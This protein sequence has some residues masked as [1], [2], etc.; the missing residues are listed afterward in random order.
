MKQISDLYNIGISTIYDLKKQ[1]KDILKFYGNANQLSTL[2]MRKT[3]HSS[4]N[5]DVDAILMEWIKQ[6]RSE[7]FPLTR[8][9]NDPSKKIPQ[10]VELG[11]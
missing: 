3:M 4:I 2:S 11:K 7:N 10:R 8:S 6:R 1:K 9:V 5:T